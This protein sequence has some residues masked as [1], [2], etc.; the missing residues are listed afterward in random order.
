MDKYNLA[1][2]LSRA[3]EER[4][5]RLEELHI[6]NPNL[7]EHLEKQQTTN[8]KIIVRGE[9][10]ELSPTREL[11]LR[12]QILQVEPEASILSEEQFLP[13]EAFL[14]GESFCLVGKA[15]TGKTTDVKFMI[16]IAEKM[17]KLRPMHS[18]DNHKWLRAGSLGVAV[19]AFTN[20]AVNNIS[21]SFDLGSTRINFLTIHKMLEY[22]KEEYEYQDRESGEWKKSFRFIPTRDRFHRLPIGLHSQIIEEASMVS[23][24]DLHAKLVAASE[25]HIR[26]FIWGTCNNYRPFTVTVYSVIN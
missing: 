4:E 14:R 18:T 8:G 12:E 13:I 22:T 5:K 15:G 26:L 2:I 20:R 25:D 17:H 9:V 21:K 7:A 10:I 19:M 3:R 23:K 24:A 11:T 16:R 6:V 1:S